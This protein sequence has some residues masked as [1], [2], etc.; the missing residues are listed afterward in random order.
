M[1]IQASMVGT[2]VPQSLVPTCLGSRHAPT[3][4][5]LRWVSCVHCC[6]FHSSFCFSLRHSRLISTPRY[7]QPSPPPPSRLHLCLRLLL[8]LLATLLTAALLLQVAFFPGLSDVASWAPYPA[9]LLFLWAAGSLFAHHLP[10]LRQRHTQMVS[11]LSSFIKALSECP[12]T[13]MLVR[14]RFI[15]EEKN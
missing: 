9:P 1:L 15:E 12:T 3:R 11:C 6:S 4:S 5:S 8:L 2:T 10:T 14:E 7:R 13:G